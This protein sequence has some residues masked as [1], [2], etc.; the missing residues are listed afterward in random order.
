MLYTAPF[1]DL[2]YVKKGGIIYCLIPANYPNKSPNKGMG[3]RRRDHV[4]HTSSWA[5]FQNHHDRLC[6]L[7]FGSRNTIHGKYSRPNTTSTC[8]NDPERYNTL[9]SAPAPGTPSAS[10]RWIHAIFWSPRRPRHKGMAG[11]TGSPKSWLLGSVQRLS[12]R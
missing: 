4:W 10:V 3:G 7:F 5:P 9:L 8:I 6:G 2:P 12:F 11:R 1:R